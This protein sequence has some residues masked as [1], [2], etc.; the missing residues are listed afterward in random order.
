MINFNLSKVEKSLTAETAKSPYG[1]EELGLM[2]QKKKGVITP[3]QIRYADFVGA[4]IPVEK[5]VTAYDMA[6]LTV[7]SSL[8]DMGEN[9]ITLNRILSVM[10]GEKKSHITQAMKEK[11][12]E[13][14][15]KLQLTFLT[16]NCVNEVKNGMNTIETREKYLL[17]F[18]FSKIKKNRFECETIY[19]KERPILADYVK[20]KKQ[21]ASADERLLAIS[22]VDT[23]RAKNA[24]LITFLLKKVSEIKGSKNLKP[25]IYY[26]EIFKFLGVSGTDKS[27]R[28][29][30]TNIRKRVKKI[31]EQWLRAKFL[32]SFS[33]IKQ[34]QEIIKISFTFQES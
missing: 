18:E 19:I 3:V 23:N 17:I 34:K 16:I 7:V 27:I 10:A 24:E 28:V 5:R 4:E 30:K 22:G 31:F 14:L 20:A 15:K 6:V 33:E 1:Y 12:K 32:T 29:K 11:L 8:Y 2:T 26:E 9:A 21:V 25:V 13:S